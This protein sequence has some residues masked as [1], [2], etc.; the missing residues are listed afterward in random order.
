MTNQ[1]GGWTVIQRCADNT[2]NFFRGWEDY[3]AGFGDLLGNFWVG[4]ETLHL[5]SL[6]DTE[7]HIILNASKSDSP[8]AAY[9]SFTLNDEEEKYHLHVSGYTGSAGDSLSHL[10]NMKFSTKDQD[11]DLRGGNCAQLYMGA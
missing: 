8:Y 6:G 9:G 3:K 4:L 11:N 2:V 1:G 7:L 10:D 5:L